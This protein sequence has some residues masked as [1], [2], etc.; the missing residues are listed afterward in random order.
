MTRLGRDAGLD[1]LTV[2][3]RGGVG[4]V[5]RRGLRV[6]VHRFTK[7]DLVAQLILKIDNQIGRQKMAGFKQLR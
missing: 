7:S 2:G 4:R 1:G 5:V 6:A 3:L